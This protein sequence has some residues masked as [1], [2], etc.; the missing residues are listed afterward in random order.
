MRKKIRHS[1][2]FKRLRCIA[3]ELATEKDVLLGHKV[4]VGMWVPDTKDNAPVVAN[5]LAKKFRK[6]HAHHYVETQKIQPFWQY[7]CAKRLYKDMKRDG[8]GGTVQ[9]LDALVAEVSNVQEAQ[10][11]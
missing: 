11:V 7:N 1:N 4:R 8:W 5:P 9:Q 10:R 6:K 3:K 2:R